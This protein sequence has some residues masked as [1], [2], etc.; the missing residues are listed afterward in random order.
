MQTLSDIVAAVVV[1]S[2]TAAFSHFGVTLEPPKVERPAPERTV[3]RTA[4][5]PKAKASMVMPAPPIE[6]PPK[7]TRA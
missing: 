3:N 2:S 1:S 6:G 5:A 7:P 4:P